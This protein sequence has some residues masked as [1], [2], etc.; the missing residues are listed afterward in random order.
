[1]GIVRTIVFVLV[2][3]MLTLFTWLGG[4]IVPRWLAPWVPWLTFLILEVM[5]L[6]PEQRRNESLLEARSRVGRAVLR[7]PLTWITVLITLFLTTQ[8]LNAYTFLEWNPTNQ[9]WDV[10]SPAFEWLCHPSV[11]ALL[12][13]PPADPTRAAFVRIPD[14]VPVPWLPHALRSDEA[15]T[16]LAWF[17][18]VLVAL[19]ALRH[20]TLRHSKR[21]MAAFICAMT[22]VLAIAGIIQYVVGGTFLYWGMESHAFFFATFGYP[23]HAAC[24]FPAVMALSIG[25]FLWVIEHREHTR[26]PPWCYILSAILCAISAILSGSRAGVL[27]TLAIVGFTAIYIPIRYFGSMSPKMRIAVPATLFAM[28]AVIIGTAA[29]RIYAVNANTERALAMKTAETPE[30]YEATFQLPSYRAIPA[31]D[32]VLKEIGDTDW[33]HFISHPM[34]MRAG[35]QGILAIRQL[36]DFPLFGAGAWSF[37]WLNINYINK[38]DPEEKTWL[39]SRQGVGQ[40]NVHNDALQFLAEHG[41]VGFGLML[42]CIAALAIPFWQALLRS[43]SIPMNDTVA[44]R[45]WFN[46]ICAYCVFALVATTLIAAH[47]FIDLIFRSPACMMLYGLLFV[48]AE[49]FV[50][51]KRLPQAPL[52]NG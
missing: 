1:M 35:Y 51:K 19:L 5:L 33:E 44:D 28:A 6:L 50:P 31:I 18:P 27:F 52:P 45:V 41:W 37:R 2:A 38:D 34:L 12:K 17:T 4:G 8:W 14:S 47:S 30:A 3:L 7:D 10:V 32:T 15:A 20:A 11:E 49:G 16:V 48:C 42:A 29:F 46:R 39:R 23:N 13:S 26:I 22:S 24:F 36:E 40:A 25:M 43:P 21:L 9:A